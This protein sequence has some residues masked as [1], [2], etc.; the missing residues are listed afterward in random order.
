MYKKLSI[1][2]TTL[3]AASL[4]IPS[5]AS[6]S[7]NTV[8]I[9]VL[10]DMSSAYSDSSGI[11][12][13]VAAEMAV[14]DYL[15]A[16]G[17]QLDIKIVSADHQNKPDVGASIARRW[18][19]VDGVDMIT[20]VPTSSVGLAVNQ[21]AKEKNKVYVNT[22]TGVASLTGDQCTP[23]TVDWLYDTWEVSHAIGKAVVKN[24]GDSWFF[25]TADYAFGHALESDTAQVVEQTGGSVLGRAR[26][27]LG[28]SDF[29]SYLLQ[30]QASKAKIIGLAN[31]AGDTANSIK[32]AVEFRLTDSQKLAAFIMFLPDIHALGLETAQGLLL[33]EPFY[34]D[35]NEGT[36]EWTRRF[37]ERNNGKYP[38][39]NQAGVYAGT[40]HYL[41]AVAA[42]NS[43]EGEIVVKKMK[44]LPT[45]DIL[46]GQGKI[47]QDG[48]K[49][50][51][52]FLFEVKNPSESKY[53]Y[54]YYNLVDT[55]PAEEAFRPLAEGNCP[56][57]VDS[58]SEGQ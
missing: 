46:F 2:I 1:A 30:A 34:W 6:I 19:D 4:S 10:N 29:S 52:V 43:D 36:R 58:D 3:S 56:L 14:E 24:G 26:A 9:G 37:A 44:E 50:H 33:A 5:L 17:S 21:I 47:R 45:D 55:I 22:G 42:A 57:V 49:I 27:P 13:V 32:Q 12:S 18:F 51:P 8:K 38:S 53:P 31:A 7:D 54:D 41:K 23:N 11:G 35:M 25:L 40:L 28:T 20:D 48:R 15:K 39:A 16:T